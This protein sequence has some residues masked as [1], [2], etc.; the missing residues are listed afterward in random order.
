MAFVA[1][2]FR[3]VFSQVEPQFPIVNSFP[4]TSYK[5]HVLYC[6]RTQNRLRTRARAC[7]ACNLAKV[8]C[9]LQSRCSRCLS[10][11]L[12]CVY[13]T[14]TTT[15]IATAAASNGGQVADDGQSQNV[16]QAFTP[17]SFNDGSITGN[18]S[19]MYAFGETQIGMGWDTLDFVP[20][21]MLLQ[22]PKSNFPHFPDPA[23]EH[24]PTEPLLAL[25]EWSSFER[26]PCQGEYPP[27][28]VRR[29]CVLP[30]SDFLSPIPKSDPVKNCIAN[31][32]M[33]MLRA[34]PQM[35][36]RRE[37]FPP[38]IHGHWYRTISA[39]EPA[40]PEP[41]VNCMGVA[42]VFVSHNLEIKPFLWRMIQSEQSSMA[43]KVLSA[44]SHSCTLRL[45][46][47]RPSSA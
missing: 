27:S 2:H 21:D 42:Q 36:L 18:S 31:V 4:E 16:T 46:L 34:F 35:M 9:N 37:T 33:Q 17:I 1:N 23:S 32:A 38:F 14:T 20:N 11:N 12:D 25:A 41:L 5:R 26:E 8:K 24:M 6:R 43:K 15:A 30:I 10:K 40:L 45:I 29:T 22:S 3:K 19:G 44:D 47:S 13:D 28:A 39:I 7:R